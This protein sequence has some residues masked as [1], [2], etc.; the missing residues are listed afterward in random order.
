MEGAEGLLPEEDAERLVVAGAH[1]GKDWLS[2]QEDSDLHA[3]YTVA[4]DT[5]LGSLDDRFEARKRELVNENED[6]ADIQL[7]MLEK[8]HATQSA[9]LEEVAAKHRSR[10]RK[11]LLM[12]TEGRMKALLG[13]VERRRIEIEAKRKVQ[14]NQKEIAVGL[15]IVEG[16]V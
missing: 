4:N 9:V 6:R 3:A 10:G 16:E 2:A 1:F 5:C 15:I 8:H 13:R 11:A 7:R 14:A 12:A